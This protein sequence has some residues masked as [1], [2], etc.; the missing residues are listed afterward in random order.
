M[1]VGGGGGDRGY[2]LVIFLY[3]ISRLCHFLSIFTDRFFFLDFIQVVF[4]L[5]NLYEITIFLGK[6]KIKFKMS[7][8]ATFIQHA[9]R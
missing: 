9:K 3:F 7:S 2:F 1:C 8:A 5:D 4:L 6:N